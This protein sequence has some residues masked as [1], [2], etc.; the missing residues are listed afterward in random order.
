VYRDISLM[1]LTLHDPESARTFVVEELGE[2]AGDGPKATLLRE[3]LSA[4]F[5]AGQNAAAAA[6]ALQINDR[7]VAYR[8]RS[9]EAQLGFPIGTRRDELGVALRLAEIFSA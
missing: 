4:Y 2:L 5:A 9:A 1:A 6:A 3:T 7:T 8:V